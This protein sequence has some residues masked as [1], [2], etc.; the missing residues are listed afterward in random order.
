MTEM[1][2]DKTS[3][4]ENITLGKCSQLNKDIKSVDKKTAIPQNK[5]V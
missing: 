1:L 2:E 4:D 3:P 5:D